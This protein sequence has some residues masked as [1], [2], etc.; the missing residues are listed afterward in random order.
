[1]VGD[2]ASGGQAVAVEH[3]RDQ[4]VIGENKKLALLDLTMTACEKCR[5]GVDDDRNT[6]RG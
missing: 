2:F 1:L 3:G 6:V 4:A 5:R